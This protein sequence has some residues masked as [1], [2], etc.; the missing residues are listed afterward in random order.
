MIFILCLSGSHHEIQ[1]NLYEEVKQFCGKITEGKGGV[2]VIF[3]LL[4]LVSHPEI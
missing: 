4:L 2:G 3:T 1:D